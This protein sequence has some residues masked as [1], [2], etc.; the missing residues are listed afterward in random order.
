MKIKKKNM[1]SLNA[2][3]AQTQ[4]YSQLTLAV[5]V[6]QVSQKLLEKIGFKGELIE[7]QSILPAGFN[8]R[9]RENLEGKCHIRKD[10]P[11]EKYTVEWDITWEDWGGNSHSR[12]IWFDRERNARSYDEAFS[13]YLTI[14]SI[15]GKQYISADDIIKIDANERLNLHICNLML[16]C[17]GYFEVFDADLMEIKRSERKVLNWDILPPGE[18]P[19]NSKSSIKQLVSSKLS[20]QKKA[21][22]ERR[23]GFIEKLKP[24]FVASGRGGFNHYFIYGFEARNT[25]ILESIN[26]NNATYVFSDD[27]RELSQLTKAEIIQGDLAKNRIIHNASWET[28]V[29]KAVSVLEKEN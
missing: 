17:F 6:E 24:D 3:Y 10:L 11:K 4:D 20:G 26:D 29:R 16:S 15:N 28:E 23:T 27:W 5:P 19:W 2:L 1:R 22:F 18:Y 14:I 9:T 25:F 21:K 8:L 7:G 12:T 13:C